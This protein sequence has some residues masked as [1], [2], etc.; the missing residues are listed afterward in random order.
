LGKAPYGA[1]YK[2][3]CAAFTRATIRLP[4]G[5]FT[6]A[7]FGPNVMNVVFLCA[8]IRS[9]RIVFRF[10]FFQDKGHLDQSQGTKEK[11][12]RAKRMSTQR[13]KRGRFVQV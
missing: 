4:T 13:K 1:R 10:R 2:E 6:F 3:Y 9:A 11:A 12:V 5:I 7:C 8:L